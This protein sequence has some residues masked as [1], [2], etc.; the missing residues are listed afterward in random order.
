MTRN[1]FFKLFEK[2][3]QNAGL[4]DIH[5]HLLRHGTGFRL[6]NDNRMDSLSLAAYLGHAN[7]QN[8]KSYVQMSSTR[9]DGLWRD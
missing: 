2:A 6:V 5:P 1:V 8:T 7:V 3:G 9:F 4:D